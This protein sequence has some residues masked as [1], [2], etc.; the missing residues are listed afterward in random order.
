MPVERRIRQGA[1]RNADVLTP[2]VDAFLGS[3]VRRARRR[4]LLRRSLGAAV[5][6][7]VL[8]LVI[9]A[10]PSAIQAIRDTGSTVTAT[11][12]TITGTTPS[13]S[14]TT[15]SPLLTGVFTRTLKDNLAVV[16]ANGIAGTWTISAGPG[17]RLRLVSPA[18]FAGDGTSRP[19]EMQTDTLSTDAFGGGVCSGLP[20]GTYRWAHV[21]R[22]LI[23]TAIS[24]ACD[25]RV[26][27][28]ASGPWR[29]SS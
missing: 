12:P 19:F 3:V 4:T 14:A 29:S 17:G 7:P 9:V 23:L 11:R 13:P 18:S 1:H 15:V 22:Y 20:S 6:I 27:V 2:D 21:G 10:G 24:D 28:L 5:A 26:V 16:Q 8:A 25:A